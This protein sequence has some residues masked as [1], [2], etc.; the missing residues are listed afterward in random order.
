MSADR[1]SELDEFRGTVRGSRPAR[2]VGGLRAGGVAADG[3]AAGSTGFAVS[4][5]TSGSSL[6]R[7][8][9]MVWSGHRRRARTR[10]PST[11]R[12]PG[13]SSSGLSSMMRRHA[14]PV[15]IR[16]R[17]RGSRGERSRAGGT[18]RCLLL[19]R[20][21]R[22][23]RVRSSRVLVSRPSSTAA[24]IAESIGLCCRVRWRPSTQGVKKGPGPWRSRVSAL[25]S[26]MVLPAW[27]RDDHF[28]AYGT[29]AIGDPLGVSGA[30]PMTTLRHH[31]RDDGSR[32][33]LLTMCEGSAR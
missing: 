16:Q 21:Q 6:S 10:W 4:A 17:R 30:R 8:G 32:Y 1:L 7:A 9:P 15:R 27:A 12:R 18:G 33:R 26:S 23:R 11:T 20:L 14:P 28:V 2:Y 25:S 31:V 5:R 3:R 24:G 22:C 13:S 29:I 19:G